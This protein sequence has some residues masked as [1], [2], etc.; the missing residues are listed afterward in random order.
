MIRRLLNLFR[1]PD[2]EETAREGLQEL[3][4]NLDQVK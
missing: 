1:R 3:L 2:P 4:P